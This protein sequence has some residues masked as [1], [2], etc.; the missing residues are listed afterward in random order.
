MVVVGWLVAAGHA[1]DVI[2]WGP[3][4]Y[5]ETQTL[6]RDSLEYLEADDWWGARFNLSTDALEV[7]AKFWRGENFNDNTTIVYAEVRSASPPYSVV[8]GWSKAFDLK[9]LTG[10]GPGGE[11]RSV[12]MVQLGG[13]LNGTYW[14]CI[15]AA[16]TVP[17]RAVLN[18]YEMDPSA[19]WD[20]L[21]GRYVEWDG[22]IYRAAHGSA[23]TNMGDAFIRI[24]QKL[25]YN[26]KP[27]AFID[28]IAPNPAVAGQVVSFDGHGEDSGSIMAYEW[29]LADGTLLSTNKAFNRVFQV[30]VYTVRFRVRDDLVCWSNYVTK[31]L[32]VEAAT[33]PTI[34]DLRDGGGTDRLGNFIAGLPITV[35]NTYS[36]RVDPGSFAADHVIFKIAKQGGGIQR[37]VNTQTHVGNRWYAEFTVSDLPVGL[38]TASATAYDALSNPS[39]TVTKNFAMLSRPSWWYQN[40]VGDDSVSWNGQSREYTFTCWIY[41][42]PPLWWQQ[43]INFD[44][45]GT[46][47]NSAGLRIDVREKY[48]GLTDAWTH[49]ANGGL[50]ATLLGQRVLDEPFDISWNNAQA[51]YQWAWDSGTILDYSTT[52]FDATVFEGWVY[53]VVH[54]SVRVCVDF[55]IDA[56][57]TVDGV[58]KNDLD[59]ENLC[60][61]PTVGAEVPITGEVTIYW[62]V[63]SAGFQATPRFE[64]DVPVCYSFSQGGVYLPG[65]C[66]RFRATAH[67]WLDIAWGYGHW[68]TGEYTLAQAQWGS[69][70]DKLFW[71]GPRGRADPP[72][73]F[74]SPRIASDGQGNAL[75]VWIHDHNSGTPSPSPDVYYS[76][77]DANLAVWSVPKAVAMT[78]LFETDPR[79]VFT[80]QKKALL[81]VTQNQLTQQQCEN[82]PAQP[83]Y[84]IHEAIVAEQEL[85]SYT[86]DGALDL[87]TPRGMVKTDPP[88]IMNGARGDGRAELAAASDGSGQ[89]IVVWVRDP[90]GHLPDAPPPQGDGEVCDTEIWAARWLGAGWAPAQRLSAPGVGCVDPD[91]AYDISGNGN[92]ACVWVCD[93]DGQMYGNGDRTIE[94]AYFKKSP[95]VWLPGPMPA[96]QGMPGVLWPTV[97]FDMFDQPVVVFT[98]RGPGD[99]KLP[100]G[101]WYGEGVHD[102]LFSACSTPPGAYPFAFDKVQP[103]GGPFQNRA[104]WPRLTVGWTPQGPR[105]FVGCRSFKGLGADGYGG[106]LGITLKDLESTTPFDVFP[107]PTFFTR[108]A[109]VDWQVD[110]DADNHFG[111]L[112]AVWV[113]P[114]ETNPTAPFGQGFDGI[115]LLEVPLGPDVSVTAEHIGVSC[116]YPQ[117]GQVVSLMAR[118]RN[119]G[120]QNAWN[121]PVAFYLDQVSPGNLV[122]TAAV[123]YSGYHHLNPVSV[124]WQA[125]GRSHDLIVVVDPQN[126]IHEVNEENNVAQLSFVAMAPPADL[127]L[128]AD[129]ANHELALAWLPP[130]SVDPAA[131]HAPIYRVYRD[132]GAGY[133]QVAEVAGTSYRDGT[134]AAA[135]YRVTAVSDGG[136]ESAA[137]GPVSGAVPVILDNNI[138]RATF[139]DYGTS[140][141]RFPYASGVSAD[142]AWLPL[143]EGTQA[144][145]WEGNLWYDGTNHLLND[146]S[147]FSVVSPLHV[148]GPA[149]AST[150]R[151]NEFQ[152]VATHS[153]AGATLTTQLQVTNLS[154][155]VLNNVYLAWM[156]DGDLALPDPDPICSS[157]PWIGF[158]SGRWDGAAGAG[159]QNNLNYAAGIVPPTAALAHSARMD[160]VVAPTSWSACNPS[161]FE[162]RTCDFTGVNLGDPRYLF[163]QPF[164]NTVGCVGFDQDLSL[165]TAFAVTA[166]NPGVSH[167]FT[168]TLTFHRPG[169]VEADGLISFS[170]FASLQNCLH[171]PHAGPV[172]AACT[173]FDFQCD[174]DVDLEDFADFQR[175]FGE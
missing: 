168:Y 32:Q 102:Y 1:E 153:L 110:L 51:R 81:V 66:I 10:A 127:A 149:L 64:Y 21:T 161:G 23:D 107:S 175:L 52:L 85:V 169:D 50:R 20:P 44:P 151:N 48:L 144:Y 36:V 160:G 114:S 122:G 27:T 152:V 112:R 145:S 170:D 150:T 105:G 24:R 49:Q 157:F 63:A 33:P 140:G 4:Q 76:Y 159:A 128:T 119:T 90:D 147:Q 70:C 46:L 99:G 103:V 173:T 104:Q 6:Y 65:P 94:Y 77:Y 138:I 16:G 74:Q 43:D 171:G 172:S 38:Y 18:Y 80:G 111:L 53:G 174:D 154:G 30:G 120:D 57:L 78:P 61:T 55:G 113:R 93:Q 59:P 118:V 58:I 9:G 35:K 41:Y 40:W 29:S 88:G 129:V 22:L 95:G 39:A 8:P 79:V 69:G 101:A 73:P 106:D 72:S 47:E 91:V 60:I 12:E 97:C 92:A 115:M 121:V 15:R 123:P 146:P 37:E 165:I 75:C 54:V 133:Q 100:S 162:G 132:I 31:E 25:G 137:A 67:A 167:T 5:A 96:V 135:S 56:S 125:D 3:T 109:E 87:W 7:S 136:A 148:D 89:T 28:S 62:G 134:V 142:I 26:G 124:A 163:Q 126:A 108:D 68:D 131:P 71:V 42:Y 130:E 17:A 34:G 14:V 164:D 156:L 116:P 11:W 13:E 117:S 143:M 82:M 19:T 98:Q 83:P 86:Y 45:L 139:N 155:R 84:Q 166:W 2:N 141:R 158:G